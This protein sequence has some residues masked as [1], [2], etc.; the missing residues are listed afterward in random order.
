MRPDRP[1]LRLVATRLPRHRVDQLREP[2][3]ERRDDALRDDFGPGEAVTARSG[4]QERLLVNP[5]PPR[6]VVVA[7]LRLRERGE[8]AHVGGELLA[9]P[10]DPL[11]IRVRDLTGAQVEQGVERVAARR[12]DH[13]AVSLNRHGEMVASPEGLE[14]TA[15]HPRGPLP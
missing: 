5:H 7:V 14:T 6:V 11:R 13:R 3:V 15:H 10:H 12:V 4:V 2:L 8:I 1:E 9:V